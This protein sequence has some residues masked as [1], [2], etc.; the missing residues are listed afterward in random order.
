[1]TAFW[2]L[3]ALLAL[4]AVSFLF[5][6]LLRLRKLNGKWSVAGLT[7]TAVIVPA[8][9][10]LY[11]ITSSWN[12]SEITPGPGTESSLP[13]VAEMVANLAERLKNNS[14]DA[15]GWRLLGQSYMALG[16]YPEARSAFRE[17]WARTPVADDELKLALGEAEVLS[18]QESLSS[19]E[20]GSLFEEV[21]E[22]QPM[23]PRALWYGGLVALATEREGLARQR[24][25][26][27]LTLNPPEEVAKIIREQFVDLGNSAPK[28]AQ[29]N[30]NKVDG[31]V[32]ALNISVDET[33]SSDTLSAKSA[34]FIFAQAPEGGPPL[35]VIRESITAV[36]GTFFLSDQDA[37]IPGRSLADFEVLNI[38]ARLSIT[39]QPIQQPG[40][41]YGEFQY[42]REQQLSSVDL[43]INQVAD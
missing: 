22:L 4:L 7:T 38:V 21:L 5:Y 26:G 39:G 12:S 9:F 18:N 1:M 42:E 41:L 31:A 29:S 19:S 16:N 36:P 24:W 10:F 3:S 30:T 37:M 13:P 25:A 34:L 8:A 23:N 33:L 20:V 6:P 32:I 35:A 43:T 14:D 28:P 40:D 27:L 11:S 17:A 2:I 15:D